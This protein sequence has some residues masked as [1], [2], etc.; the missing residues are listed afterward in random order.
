MDTGWKPPLKCR[1]MPEEER[2][3]VRDAFRIVIDGR[4]VPPPILSFQASRER[5][6][7]RARRKFLQG[8]ME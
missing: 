1:L 5:E 3:K 8:G 7:E 6:R 4:N 2:Q